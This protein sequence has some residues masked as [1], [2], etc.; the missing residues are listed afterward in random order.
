MTPVC[1]NLISPYGIKPYTI[2][3]HQFQ[4]LQQVDL[5]TCLLQNIPRQLD[6]SNLLP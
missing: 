2:C 4:E 6:D 1:S 3:E 5:N